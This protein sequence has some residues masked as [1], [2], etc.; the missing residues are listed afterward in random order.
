MSEPPDLPRLPEDRLE[1]LPRKISELKPGERAI[2]SVISNIDVDEEGH[3][4]VDASSRAR[5]TPLVAGMTLQ[6]ERTQRGF[7]LWLDKKVKFTR[8]P[9]YRKHYLPIV[10]FREGPGKED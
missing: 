7:I 5:R 4:W 3:V 6:A 9:L 8:G 10:E 2:L 1:P